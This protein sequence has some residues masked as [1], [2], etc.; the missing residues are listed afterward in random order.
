MMRSFFNA[1]TGMNTSRFWLD[2][3]SDN[4]ANANTVGYKASRPIFQEMISQAI[5]S[6]N[7]VTG[8][9][10]TTV[11]GAGSI[12]DSTQKIWTVGNFKQTDI[13]TDL[14][15][16][17]KALFILR[18]AKANKVFYTRDGRFR[19][20]RAGYLVNANGL[21]VQGFKVDPETGKVVGTDLE[22]IRVDTQI[23]P[24]VTGK[25]FFVQPTNLDANAEV[26]SGDL[27]P[28]DPATYNYKYTITIYDS[29]G[30]KIPTDIYF[31]KTGSNTWKIYVI[32]RL[33]ERDINVDWDGDT[34]KISTI[35]LDFINGN[36]QVYNP[37][38]P[39]P[40]TFTSDKT[41]EFDSTTG[42]LIKNT[43]IEAD[44]EELKYYIL[45]DRLS[46]INTEY[47]SRLGAK[48]GVD[49]KMRVYVGEGA[50]E[51]GNVIQ[52]PYLT[53]HASDFTVTMDQDGYESGELMDVYVSS[54][55]GVVMGVYSNGKSVPLYRIALAEFT[56]PEELIRQGANLYASSKPP[57]ILLPGKA[58]KIRS[59]MVEMSNVDIAKEFINLITAQ[60]TYQANARVIA[61]TNTILDDMI[62][63]VR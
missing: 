35:F 56:D 25:I 34:K 21:Y 3:V 45:L 6:P 37:D 11:L 29:L 17:G 14:A 58:N 9:T 53:Q 18:D 39:T 7:T 4:L 59:G 24:K 33:E 13:S 60:R 52:T 31:Q 42:K 44:N 1:V 55:D 10:K 27:N 30:R 50:L 12:V 26:I 36:V 41:L 20:N 62:N 43:S 19:V 16:E 28:F 23:P 40:I 46:G 38:S 15:I 57:R 51:A 8:T 61:S 48:V 47:E 5:V 54:G 49:N 2:V 63:L 22:D 32:G